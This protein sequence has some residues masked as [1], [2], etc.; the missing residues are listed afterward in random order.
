[1]VS[2]KKNKIES[3]ENYTDI[4]KQAYN[5]SLK[6][7]TDRVEVRELNNEKNKNYM[8][9]V[10]DTALKS[11]NKYDD[12]YYVVVLTKRERLISRAIRNL[13]FTTQAC[14]TPSYEQAVYMFNPDDEVLDFLWIVPS[15]E[16][17]NK[18]YQQRYFIELQSDPLL[19]FVI[20][21]VEGKLL[22]KAKFLNN[23]Y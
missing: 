13:F 19:P 5:K 9:T 14:P 23:E 8:A 11:K 18:M 10:I 16:M 15:K 6:T 4:G 20:D 17:C 1:M 3:P 21:F 7:N 22:E 2:T 12:N